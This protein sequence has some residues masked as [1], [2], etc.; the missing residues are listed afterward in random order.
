MVD[1]D[2]TLDGEL[3]A[4]AFS[5]RV[6]DG[7]LVAIVAHE[8]VGPGGALR[9][10]L[11]VAHRPRRRRWRR[12]PTFDEVA[13]ARYE[14]GPRGTAMALVVPGLGSY[15]GLEGTVLHLV[16]LAGDDLEVVR[17]LRLVEDVSKDQ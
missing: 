12:Y 14:L 2:V 3:V 4:R 17:R 13:H 9:W 8:P 16:E 7:D 10:H 11:S 6:R 5:R 1:R 15:V